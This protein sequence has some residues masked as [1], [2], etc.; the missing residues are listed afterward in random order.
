M[1]AKKT[2]KLAK[3]QQRSAACTQAD[4]NRDSKGRFIKGNTPKTSFR[5]R[6]QDIYNI[7]D[8]DN[9]NPKHSPRFQLRKLWSVPTDEVEKRIQN[10]KTNKKTPYGE[11][12]A[13]AQRYG[14]LRRKAKSIR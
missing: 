14:D 3:K 2:K 8:D 4:K 10:A 5:D 13:L 1:T 9:F 11:Y 7:A 12:L 6:P